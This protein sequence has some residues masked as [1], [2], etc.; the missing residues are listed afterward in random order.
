ME[1]DKYPNTIFRGKINEEVDWTKDGEH[2]VTVSGKMNMHGVE[3]DITLDG[4]VI[5]KGKEII[6]SSKFKIHIEDYKIKVPTI[7]VD[8]IAEDVDVKIDA[9]LIPFKK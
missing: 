2:K 6:I 9:V 5:I 4:T 7:Y 3:R 1:S 8:N